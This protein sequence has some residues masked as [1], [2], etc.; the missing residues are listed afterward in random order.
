MTDGSDRLTAVPC[1]AERR[2]PPAVHEGSRRDPD[3]LGGDD[4]RQQWGKRMVEHARLMAAGR[5][6]AVR[7]GGLA[8]AARLVGVGPHPAP[9]RDDPPGRT[10]KGKRHRGAATAVGVLSAAA[11]MIVSAGQAQADEEP[12]PIPAWVLAHA[13][14]ADH[15]YEEIDRIGIGGSLKNQSSSEIEAQHRVPPSIERYGDGDIWATFAP[16]QSTSTPA[17]LTK[18]TSIPE[19]E[20]I[21]YARRE[22]EP[23]QVVGSDTVGP[24]DCAEDGGDGGAVDPVNVERWAGATRV[25][26]AVEVSRKTFDG[27]QV[28]TAVVATA[29]DYPD[30]LAGGPLAELVGGPVMLTGSGELHGAVDDEL[31]R[32]GPDGGHVGEVYVLGGAAAVSEGVVGQ[33]ETRGI[34][35]TRLGGSDRFE[36]AEVVARE[37]DRLTQELV[38]DD[39]QSTTVETAAATSET[40]TARSEVLIARGGDFADALAGASLG[41]QEKSPVLLTTQDELPP[42]TEAYLEQASSRIEQVTVL[43]G[44]EAVSPTVANQAA[45]AADADTTERI[46]GSTRIDTALQVAR[47]KLQRTKDHANE[48]IIATAYNWPDA[49]AGGPASSDA[50]SAL[51]LVNGHNAAAN[52]SYTDFVAEQRPDAQRDEWDGLTILGGHDTISQP[53]ADDLISTTNAYPPSDG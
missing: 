43:G 24:K 46:A 36:T 48:A 9:N 35:V 53:V 49:L 39:P 13:Q 10:G 42:A 12:E 25:E 3:P 32:L 16:G 18:E 29:E 52:S 51:V 47:E 33:L 41:A 2:S 19:T 20:V 44:T 50:G 6:T 1:H 17:V 4:D 11:V 30:A 28:E 15:P 27:G 22:G 23:E 5:A 31:D 14:C 7:L 45:R 37:V 40:D 26:T 21:F 38:D 34:T 8:W